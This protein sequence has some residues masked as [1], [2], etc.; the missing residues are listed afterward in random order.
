MREIKGKVRQ[1]Q[2]EDVTSWDSVGRFRELRGEDVLNEA[3]GRIVREEL[4]WNDEEKGRSMIES[5][6]LRERES[7]DD[8]ETLRVIDPS[9][10]ERAIEILSDPNS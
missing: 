4:E 7:H 5:I 3:E 1:Y 10:A 6:T 2:L 9:T 8:M